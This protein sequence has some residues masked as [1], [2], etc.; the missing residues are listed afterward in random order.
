[1]T[2]SIF[3]SLADLYKEMDAAWDKTAQAHEFQCN[4][5]EDNCCKSL[6]FHH[7]HI[8]KDYLLYGFSQ[9]ASDQQQVVKKL[10]QEY[11]EQT[12]VQAD[13]AE[14]KKLFC[15]VNE[16][17]KCLLYDYRPMIC[18]LHG[19]P[20]EL[21]RPNAFPLRGPGCE[22]GNFGSDPQP[23]LNRTPFYQQ[24]AQIEMEYKT[25]T[26]KTTRLKESIA[27]ILLPDTNN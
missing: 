24:L 21:I 9:L 22:A 8:E 6:F 1:M 25:T 5:C 16:D 26:G 19:V 14:S 15:P 11:Y 23:L 13:E 27:Q 20:H 2:P 7:T 17:G 10:A 3:S 18:R 4:G 12:F